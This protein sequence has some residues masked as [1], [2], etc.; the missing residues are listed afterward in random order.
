MKDSMRILAL[1]LAAATGIDA[2]L[3]AAEPAKRNFEVHQ[4]ATSSGQALRETQAALPL[5]RLR[6]EVA[7]Y[8]RDV[9][10]SSSL[11][12]RM[13]VQSIESDHDLFLFLVRQ[14]EVIVN[15]WELMGVANVTVRRTGKY[16]FSADDGQGTTGNVELIYG[17][18]DTQLYMCEGAYEGSLLRRKLTGR[19]L[20][21]LR[22]QYTVDRAEKRHVTNTLD[23][24]V[25]LDNLGA[26]FAAKTLA[27]LFGKTVD[28]NFLES[29][30]FVSRLSR[31]SEENGPGMTNLAERLTKVEPATRER[32]AEHCANIHRRASERGETGAKRIASGK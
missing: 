4:A 9:A 11:Y 22:S 1:A 20:L 23:V 15:I 17:T 25:K 2:V 28:T 7:R 31:T 21:L 13:P 5:G 26:E 19:A 3:L 27:P 32:F 12:R 30:H 14:P 16:T 10:T 6:P 29:C 8:V 24:F 18:N